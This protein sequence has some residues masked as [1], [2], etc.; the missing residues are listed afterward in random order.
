MRTHDA[1]IPGK[2]PLDSLAPVGNRFALSAAGTSPAPTHSPASLSPIVALSSNNPL[3]RVWKWINHT[4]LPPTSTK[5]LARRTQEFASVL[6]AESVEWETASAELERIAVGRQSLVFRWRHERHGPLIV[7]AWPYSV[8]ARRARDHVEAGVLLGRAGLTVPQVLLWDDSFASRRRY[9]GEFVIER[10][11]PGA[12]PDPGKPVDAQLLERLARQIARLHA[13]DGAAWGKPWR[14][15]RSPDPAREW[16]RRLAAL[17]QRAARYGL[18]TFEP[19]EVRSVL[20][21]IGQTIARSHF[22]RP[23]LVHGDMNPGNFLCAPDGTI[24]W[25]DFQTV[26][27]GHPAEDFAGLRRWL[28]P[29]AQYETFLRA[30]GTAADDT[31]TH[32]LELLLALEKLSMRSR[33]LDKGSERTTPGR[34]DEEREFYET[35][36]R[37]LLH[38]LAE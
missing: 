6:A 32:A 13:V 16:T 24:T 8:P 38:G 10:E 5:R 33:R 15:R 20:G 1:R 29:H 34:L 3:C 7:R 36:A 4:A 31:L 37:K 19:A 21:T 17:G 14:G 25:I 12:Y 28:T 30:Y 26:R 23:R 11:A 27:F 18:G 22:G 9:R 35:T 2:N